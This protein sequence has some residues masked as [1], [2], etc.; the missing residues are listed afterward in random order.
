[1]DMP[2][3][4]A[5]MDVFVLPSYR[6]S[7]PRVPMEASAMGVPCVVTDI[8]G[9]REVVEHGRNGLLVPAGN[10]EEFASAI[11]TLLTRAGVAQRMAQAGRQKAVESFDEERVFEIVKAAY[12]RLL[13]RERDSPPLARQ[14]RS[15]CWAASS[16]SRSPI[17]L[18]DIFLQP[19]RQAGAQ[20]L[21]RN[22]R[23][24]P[25]APPAG[26]RRSSRALHDG[27]PSTVSTA[28][29]R[30]QRRTLCHFEVSNHAA[31]R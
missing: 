9:C 25:A 2:T 17:S 26:A 1:M 7:F 12:A 14:G 20:S 30:S 6:E 4:Y 22:G 31:A 16:R 10:A 28:A 27:C 19:G 8:P 29:P 18:S 13:R 15:E 21:H 11:L 5:L 3:L 24:V 23:S